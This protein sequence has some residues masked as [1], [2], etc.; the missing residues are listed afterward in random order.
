MIQSSI[1]RDGLKPTTPYYKNDK[2]RLGGINILFPLSRPTLVKGAA[3]KILEK[4][5][6]LFFTGFTYTFRK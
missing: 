2:V 1:C 4:N 3:Q 5:F 6:I